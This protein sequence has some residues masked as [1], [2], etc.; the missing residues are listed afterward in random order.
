MRG[1]PDM[2]NIRMGTEKNGYGADGPSSVQIRTNPY[3]SVPLG[4][5]YR[6]GNNVP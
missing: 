6:L 1:D 5:R 2:H 4:P 3:K